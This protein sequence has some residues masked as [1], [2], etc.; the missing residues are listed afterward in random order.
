[1]PR[2]AQDPTRVVTLA[3]GIIPTVRV[4]IL[5]LDPGGTTGYACYHPDTGNVVCGQLC[6]DTHHSELVALIESI[7]DQYGSLT[8]VYEQFEFR[9][10]EGALRT[11]LRN[12]IGVLKGGSIKRLLEVVSTLENILNV[13]G[14]RD[15][16]DL[17][18]REYIGV[19]KLMAQRHDGVKLYSQS[20]SE[21][22]SFVKDPKLKAL[23]WYQETV[24]MGHARDALRHLIKYMITRRNVVTPFTTAWIGAT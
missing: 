22:K 5:A 7:L 10:N 20:A 4:P 13:D 15:G 6:S 21:A 14:R 19:V 11:A 12:Y 2:A 23:G 17:T 9:Q 16:L 1:M 8:V 18:P 3:L 24:A